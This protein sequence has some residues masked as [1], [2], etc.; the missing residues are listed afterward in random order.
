MK[1][2]FTYE[3]ADRIIRLIKK[4]LEY[5]LIALFLVVSLQLSAQRDGKWLLNSMYVGSVVCNGIGDG[6]NDNGHKDWGHV[7]NAVSISFLVLTPFVYDF[8]GDRWWKSVVKYGFIRVGF[9]DWVYNTTRGLPLTYIGSTSYWDTKF[10]QKIK[11]PDGFAFGRVV[12]TTVGF[13]IPITKCQR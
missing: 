1:P 10:M 11:P 7:C 13:S 12:F 3:D 5:I 6:L 4:K 9:F 2:V 8:T